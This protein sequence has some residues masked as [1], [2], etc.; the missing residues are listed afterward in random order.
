MGAGA[1]VDWHKVD[2]LA[3]CQVEESSQLSSRAVAED[4]RAV[5]MWRPVT[6]TCLH[7]LLQLALLDPGLG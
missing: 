1:S 7:G 4:C 6:P 3:S 2:D 5:P